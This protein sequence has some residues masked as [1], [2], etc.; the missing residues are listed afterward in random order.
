MVRTFAAGGT[1]GGVLQV[2]NRSRA[3]CLLS[4]WPTFVAIEAGGKSLKGVDVEGTM[5]GPYGVHGAPVVTLTPGGEQTLSSPGAMAQRVRAR[6]RP[7]TSGSELRKPRSR[8][9]CLA[10]SLTWGLPAVV[11]THLGDPSRSAVCAVQRLTKQLDTRPSTT[12]Y[13][14]PRY[15]RLFGHLLGCNRPTVR[16][17]A[18]RHENRVWRCSLPALTKQYPRNKEYYGRL[19]RATGFLMHCA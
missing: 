18:G 9:S 2:T 10:G 16:G 11:H 5:F 4:G 15:R 1:A 8:S 17:H 13:R 3:R 12:R 19:A 7:G 6:R 14:P